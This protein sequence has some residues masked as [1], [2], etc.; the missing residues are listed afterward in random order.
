MSGTQASW[1]DT[2]ELPLE[3]WEAPCWPT[4]HH[5]GT[6]EAWWSIAE[7]WVGHA[8]GHGTKAEGQT[9]AIRKFISAM[10]NYVSDCSHTLHCDFCARSKAE[11]QWCSKLVSCSG[12]PVPVWL[13]KHIHYVCITWPR[14]HYLYLQFWQD[15]SEQVLLIKDPTMETWQCWDLISQLLPKP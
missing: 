13:C 8:G 5:V 9:E 2:N 12:M 3:P 11:K 6:K 4:Q 14:F 15:T 10:W 1:A 7:P